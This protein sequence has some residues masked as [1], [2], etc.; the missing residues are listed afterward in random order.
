M[1]QAKKVSEQPQEVQD[2]LN[3][4][5]D[6]QKFL[7]NEKSMCSYQSHLNQVQADDLSI[8]LHQL[9]AHTKQ[10]WTSQAI[11]H[12]QTQQQKKKNNQNIECLP[13]FPEFINFNYEK[14]SKY[15]K[16]DNDTKNDKKDYLVEFC[17]KLTENDDPKLLTYLV[18]NY[19]PAHFRFFLT[20]LGIQD[21]NKFLLKLKEKNA[22]ILYEFIKPVFYSPAFIHFLKEAFEPVIMPLINEGREF[23]KAQMIFTDLIHQWN[24]KRKYCPKFVLDAINIVDDPSEALYN[25]FFVPFFT[26]PH[27]FLGMNCHNKC[28]KGFEML[29]ETIL[30]LPDQENAYLLQFYNSLNNFN[31]FSRPYISEESQNHTSDP[32]NVTYFDDYDIQIL[33]KILSSNAGEKITL[34]FSAKYQVYQY[35]R[36]EDVTSIN[37]SYANDTMNDSNK[38]Y[39]LRELLKNSTRFPHFE[40]LPGDVF[41]GDEFDPVLF[42]KHYLVNLGIPSEF[43]QRLINM[44]YFVS[45]NQNFGNLSSIQF[46]E[47]AIE[48]KHV[49]IS[50][51]NK[52]VRSNNLTNE[53][54]RIQTMSKLPL[55]FIPEMLDYMI[56]L[57]NQPTIAMPER[58]S[59]SILISDPIRFQEYYNSMKG[60]FGSVTNQIFGKHNIDTIFY[61]IITHDLTYRTFLITRPELIVLD[62]LIFDFIQNHRNKLINEIKN[63]L[64]QNSKILPLLDEMSAF[65]KV[66]ARISAAFKSSCDPLQKIEDIDE[67]IKQAV[68]I[69]E[70][71]TGFV[72]NPDQSF[73]E[74]MSL[75]SAVLYH[76]NP[77]NLISVYVFLVDF[78]CNDSN[79]LYSSSSNV[80]RNLITNLSSFLH[81]I[82]ETADLTIRL[83]ELTRITHTFTE[84]LV[85]RTKPDE[86]SS[87]VCFPIRFLAELCQIKPEIILTMEKMAEKEQVYHLNYRLALTQ[88]GNDGQILKVDP[89]G[90]K[91]LDIL[92]AAPGYKNT[93]NLPRVHLYS[94]GEK[95]G[96]VKDSNLIIF[97]S[98]MQDIIASFKLDQTKVKL[99]EI[100]SCTHDNANSALQQVFKKISEE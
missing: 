1:K 36:P 27:M 93:K 28:P 83:S 9:F 20:E 17:S 2:F 94:Q 44:H 50:E 32:F 71:E 86:K 5:A 24:E 39:Y 13:F 54:R 12:I 19:I 81:R 3:M 90:F 34:E 25:L 73:D 96:V 82:V 10:Y 37:Q 11:I 78:L 6:T 88:N 4:M 33:E 97:E 15:K 95:K 42:I 47:D 26:T 74:M 21:Y 14:I 98:N 51:A 55:T 30:T 7:I 64:S 87:E 63:G 65:D 41:N 23:D 92:V 69:Y 45:M 68:S 61:H 89:I 62:D 46:Y 99:Q 48:M 67:A 52:M 49:H 22:P 77:A 31:A 29:K 66:A 16:K 40:Y 85:T 100:E 8:Q 58:I 80:F 60:Y 70:Y 43:S 72:I 75:F 84:I 91:N 76:T 18:L 38:W 57:Q 35:H 56:I 79:P 53:I 59:T